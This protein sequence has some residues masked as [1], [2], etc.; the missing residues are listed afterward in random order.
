MKDVLAKTGIIHS[1]TEKNDSPPKKIKLDHE[2]TLMQ[3]SSDIVLQASNDE[4]RNK[5]SEN[6]FA[7]GNDK[8]LEITGIRKSNFHT[9]STEIVECE[10]IDSSNNVEG[11]DFEDVNFGAQVA[12]ESDDLENEENM[13]MEQIVKEGVNEKED[14]NVERDDEMS[15]HSDLK[16]EQKIAENPVDIIENQE[17][18][19]ES[20]AVNEHDKIME[21]IVPEETNEDVEM[22]YVQNSDSKTDEQKVMEDAVVKTD[23]PVARPIE[24]LD[25]IHKE[26]EVV[27]KIQACND[28]QNIC[29]DDVKEIK[30]SIEVKIDEVSIFKDL[31]IKQ[32]AN[33]KQDWILVRANEKIAAFSFL[34]DTFALILKLGDKLEPKK[35]R[36]SVGRIVNHWEIKEVKF[37]SVHKLP[38]RV[39][40]E[41]DMDILDS[42]TFD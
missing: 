39:D 26:Q 42:G 23:N 9:E 20:R 19:N 21:H 34:E 10:K 13:V 12:T 3:T 30:E 38:G 33:E 16:N 40:E 4:C 15:L 14:S 22:H 11:N 35:S 27:N 28:D 41:L 18:T 17:A 31:E 29:F 6:E 7:T 2:T 8:D 5:S 36:K 24:T 25:D 1:L 37:V 32:L